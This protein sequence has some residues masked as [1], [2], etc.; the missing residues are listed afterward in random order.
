MCFVYVNIKLRSILTFYFTSPLKPI[1]A[2]DKGADEAKRIGVPFIKAG[3]RLVRMRRRRSG[4]RK[5]RRR[6]GRRRV[7]SAAAR[8]R[9]PRFFQ[10]ARLWRGTT[11]TGRPAPGRTCP[12]SRRRKRGT[13]PGRGRILTTRRAATR[14]LS[15]SRVA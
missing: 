1:N 4:R 14:T 10:A 7:F 13:T 6:P 15:G 11:A 12:L 5:R 8:G 9:G 2:S 3:R